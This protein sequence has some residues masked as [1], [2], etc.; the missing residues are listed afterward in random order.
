VIAKLAFSAAPRTVERI[1]VPVVIAALS[2]AGALYVAVADYPVGLLAA[3]GIALVPAM[4]AVAW[5]YPLIFPYGAYAIL[6]PFDLLLSVPQLG[7]LARLS[8]AVAGGALLFFLLRNHRVVIPGAAIAA[9]AGFVAWAFFSQLWALNPSAAAHECG[10]LLQLALLYAIVAV[11]PAKMPDV[12]A[13]FIAVV[14]G[15]IF[16]AFF[17]IHEFA[18][19]TIKQQLLTQISDRIPLVLGEQRL[20]I[21]QFADSLLLPLALIVV[22]TV[23]ATRWSLRL[24]GFAAIVV[25]VY[26]MSLAASR[27]A[28]V[29]VGAMVA[30]FLVALK[31]RRQIGLIAVALA[32]LAL[33]NHNLWSRF[34]SA[35]ASGGSGRLGI[36]SAGLAAFRQHWFFGAGSGSF[37]NAYNGVYLK[38]FQLYDMGWSRAAHN[39]LLQN[40]V[41]YGIVGLAL[42]GAIVVFAWRSVPTTDRTAPLFGMGVAVRGALLAL[43]IAGLFVDLT[44]TKVFWLALTLAALLRSCF[45]TATDSSP[46]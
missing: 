3:V 6:V 41:E 1:A 13:I 16:A 9:C 31:E 26:A 11:I 24:C 14:A 15:G 44:T 36:W 28:F 38:V 35:S 30:Y 40:G 4:I 21:N 17:G 33:A 25:L 34:L 37:A 19:P 29:A 32:A 2:F 20:D 10:T 12:R 42:L 5:K 43:C 39:M 18:H 27:E 46:T 7:T 45:A 22:S 8:G 23:R